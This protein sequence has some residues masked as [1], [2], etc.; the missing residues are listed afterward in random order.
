M[1]ET[2]AKKPIKPEETLRRYEFI[3]NTSKDWNTLINR[4]YVYEAANRAFCRAH[5]KELDEIIGA[6]LA[7]MWGHNTFQEIIKA[8]LDRCFGG[9][10]VNYQAW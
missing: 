5:N 9:H 1:A 4:D 2:M 10:E 3:V 6:S 8:K 7:S